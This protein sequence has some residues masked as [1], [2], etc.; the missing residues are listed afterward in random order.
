M[1][2][3]NVKPAGKRSA[4]TVWLRNIPE[5]SAGPVTESFTTFRS[6]CSAKKRFKMETVASVGVSWKGCG[7]PGSDQAPALLLQFHTALMSTVSGHRRISIGNMG[8][9]ESGQLVGCLL[10]VLWKF[11]ASI[12]VA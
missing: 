1:R 3:R 8:K 2:W 9:C 5:R 4:L 7:R 10:V 12:F 11:K 6:R